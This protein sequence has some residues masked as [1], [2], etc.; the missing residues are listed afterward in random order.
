MYPLLC[1]GRY[2]VPEKDGM[3][4][5]VTITASPLVVGTAMD[6]ELR[7]DAGNNSSDY[8]LD[9]GKNLIVHLKGSGNAPVTQS[10]DPPLKTRKGLVATYC[11][12]AVV[13][14]YVR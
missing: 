12:N 9:P 3:L 7:D 11:T 4:E 5:I 10:F 6:V 14:V 1:A 8:A 2:P 13:E